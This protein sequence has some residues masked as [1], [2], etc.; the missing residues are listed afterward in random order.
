MATPES[1]NSGK[2]GDGL[3]RSRQAERLTERLETLETQVVRLTDLLAEQAVTRKRRRRQFTIRFMLIAFTGFA[4]FFAWFGNVFQHSRRQ[5]RAVDRLIGQ[6]AFVMYSPRQS[7]LISLLPGDPNQP[8]ATL[9]RWL[10]HDFFRAVTNVSARQS[11]TVS[12]D[13]TEIVD[14]VASLAQLKRLR[15]ANLKLKTPDLMAL[16][17]LHELQSLDLSRTGLDRG[18]MPWLHKTRLRWFDA[19]HTNLSDRA[20]R[21]LSQCP[22]L[23]QLFLERTAITDQGLNYL[24]S[25]SQ[26][27]YLNLKRCPVS[28]GAVKKLSDA[29]P[30]C[31][32]EW[33]PLRFLA[34]GTVDARAAKRGRLVVG[35]V[36]PVDP[37]VSHR[38]AAPL[39][40][41]PNSARV[42]Q[43]WQVQGTARPGFILDTF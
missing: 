1:K 19:S 9:A 43:A 42:N 35:R 5:A 26:L 29:L 32:I 21:D 12:G 36:I 6:S 38:A 10:G 41:L 13:K 15:L 27:R 4:I 30:G 37:R 11:R 31:R 8:P 2:T 34:D 22:D 17:G 24:H 20:L 3:R 7:A 33:E 16:N 18:G 28:I 40:R 23:Q 39:D 25:M 14:A